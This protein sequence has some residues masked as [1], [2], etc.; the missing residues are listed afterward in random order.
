[1]ALTRCFAASAVEARDAHLLGTQ[2]RS[3]QFVGGYAPRRRRSSTPASADRVWAIPLANGSRDPNCAPDESAHFA[4]VDALARCH[5]PRWPEETSS[6]YAAFLP[7]PYL[8]QALT[9]AVARDHANVGR[10]SPVEAWAHGYEAARLG[11][12]LLGVL[13]ALALMAAAQAWTGSRWSGLAVGLIA[14]TYPQHVFIGAYTNSD[15]FTLAAGAA[16]VFAVTRW[17]RLGEGAIGLVPVGAAAGVVL[18]GKMSGYYLLPVTGIW[19]GWAVWTRRASVR[20]CLLALG[21]CLV[22]SAPFLVWNAVRNGG[23][24][25]GLHRYQR[26]LTEYWHGLDGRHLPNA[27]QHFVYVLARSA[28]GVFGNMNILMPRGFYRTAALL[29]MAGCCAGAAIFVRATGV[30]RRAGLWLLAGVVVNL[31]LVFYNCWYVDFSPQGRYVLLSALLLAGVGACSVDALLPSRLRSLWVAIL[32]V[33][34]AASVG[35]AQVRVY[36]RPCLPPEASSPAVAATSDAPRVT[37]APIFVNRSS[38]RTRAD[39]IRAREG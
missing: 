37:A 13:T 11:S 16:L 15:A 38:A 31:S 17:A 28:F 2:R 27:W 3:P 30:S 35:Q 23:D 25:L 34:F 33:F 9:L 29:L 19:I 10:F 24:V 26:F 4:F 21:A 12:A 6:I 8:V 20:T 39:L 14:A 22:V 5:A 7:A 1:M 32:V 18:L 36:R